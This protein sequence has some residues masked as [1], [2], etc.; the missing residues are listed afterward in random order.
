LFPIVTFTLAV[1]K[2]L[3]IVIPVY[4]DSMY[5]LRLFQRCCLSLAKTRIPD[6]LNL[7][8]LLSDDDSPVDWSDCLSY[9]SLFQPE[10][11]RRSVGLGANGNCAK[12]ISAGLA[13]HPYTVSI[14]LDMVVDPNW[15][16]QLLQL[17]EQHPEAAAWTCFNAKFHPITKRFPDGS[18]QKQSL[19]GNL[20]LV[21]RNTWIE[22]ATVPEVIKTECGHLTWDWSFLY[23]AG[24]LSGQAPVFCTAQSYAQ[25]MGM[26]GYSFGEG[27]LDYDRA[28]D[29]VGE[30]WVE[31]SLLPQMWTA[32]TAADL[33]F[34]AKCKLLL[35]Y[36]KCLLKRLLK[37]E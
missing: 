19:S 31:R 8:W 10:V 21:S 24:V 5:R 14:E 9:L 11:Q 4:I 29:F 26:I 3:S 32:W 13:V 27:L 35:G 30:T 28:L 15:L 34:T 22:P 18:L 6:G 1:I 36:G 7:Y 12:T 2:A 25:H 23:R 20:L 16:F 33:S 17:H 37:L